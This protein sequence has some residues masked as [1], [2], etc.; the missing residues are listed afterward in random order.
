MTDFN[1]KGF[2][3]SGNLL[4]ILT[5]VFSVFMIVLVT[6]VAFGPMS[7]A[8]ILKKCFSIDFDFTYATQ[9]FNNVLS[10]AAIALSVIAIIAT[11]IGLYWQFIQTEASTELKKDIKEIREQMRGFTTPVT[12]LPSFRAKGY[13]KNK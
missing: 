5:F 9:F 13:K 1:S 12:E 10:I 3:L 2:E 11:F 8:L 6:I 4:K 7:Y